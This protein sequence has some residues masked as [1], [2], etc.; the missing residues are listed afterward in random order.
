ACGIAAEANGRTNA[1]GFGVA[2]VTTG[3]GATNVLTPVAG[4]WIESLPMLVISGQVKRPD[5]LRGR[6]LRQSAVQEAAVVAMV[7]PVT[8]YAVT[9]PR[10]E[11]A[12][13]CF[14]EAIW[15][16]RNGRAGPVWLDVPLDVQAAP[17]DP[18]TLVG[19]EPP[20]KT[21]AKTDLTPAMD[22]LAGILAQ[23]RR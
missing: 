5:A 13:Y 1:A 15:H 4:A 20:A 7:K 22:K 3:P 11:D 2:L 17:I 10:P 14:E 18:A 16:M 21:L 23:A 19:F 6:P 8:K 12:R 9:I